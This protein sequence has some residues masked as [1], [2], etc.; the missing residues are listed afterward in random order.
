MANNI[1]NQFPSFDDF[2]TKVLENNI[3]LNKFLIADQ[4]QLI[5]RQIHL[6]IIIKYKNYYWSNW[7]FTDYENQILFSDTLAQIIPPLWESYTVFGDPDFKSVNQVTYKSEQPTTDSKLIDDPFNFKEATKIKPNLNQNM[8][9]F[10]LRRDFTNE[11]MDL[12]AIWFKPNSPNANRNE[13]LTTTTDFVKDVSD[14]DYKKLTDTLNFIKSFNE[15][16]ELEIVSLKEQLKNDFYDKEETNVL[17]NEKTNA[18]FTGT[19]FKGEY[20][21]NGD[22]SIDFK[23]SSN[24]NPNQ[25]ATIKITPTQITARYFDTNGNEINPGIQEDM[26]VRTQDLYKYNETI[27][28][29]DPNSSFGY[30]TLKESFRNFNTISIKYRKINGNRKYVWFVI[31]TS[32]MND[33]DYI[34]SD[35]FQCI[36]ST[37]LATTSTEDNL[38]I[39]K[40]LGMSR[41]PPSNQKSKNEKKG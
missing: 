41:K 22:G 35:G 16:V 23:V 39:I 40:V 20:D 10:G 30:V 38:S 34:H 31:T 27:L 3:V 1:I 33:G 28:F 32:L 18:H 5:F 21:Y 4:N 37:I 19:D 17:L 24:A 15:L 36:N 25:E 26:I 7:K 6:R 29:D 14:Y 2:Q 9:D 11:I 12:I 8:T 13:L